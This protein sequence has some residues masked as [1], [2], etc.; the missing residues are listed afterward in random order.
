MLTLPKQID[1]IAITKQRD[2]LYCTFD[3]SSYKEI[4]YIEIFNDNYDFEEDKDR[5]KFC[6]WLDS[7]NIKWQ[8]CGHYYINTNLKNRIYR[9]Q[10][11]IDVPID[12]DDPQF[13]LLGNYFIDEHFNKNNYPD[14]FF[15]FLRIENAYLNQFF[16]E[17]N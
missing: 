1:D 12:D 14:L 10:I 11:Y 13:Q 5:D 17:F 8:P 16:D 15:C 6:N 3:G 2:V 9:G 7:N 4:D